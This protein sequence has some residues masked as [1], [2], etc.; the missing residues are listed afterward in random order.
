MAEDR[1]SAIITGAA[2]GIGLATAQKLAADGMNLCLVDQNAEVLEA[3]AQDLSN[4]GVEVIHRAADVTKK[5]DIEAFV[6]AALD[7]F[8]RVD[9]L[10][11]IAGGAGPRNLYQI[12]EF[13][14]DDWDLVITLNLRS[15]FLACRAVIPI[16]REQKYGRI[17]NMSSSVARGRTGPVGTAGG[18]L[19]YAAAKAGILGLTSQL[20]KD[21]GQF[22]I[23]VNAVMPWLT[24]SAQGTRIRQKFEALEPELR[25]QILSLSPLN[26]P[27][28]AGEVG[29]AIA[30]L[31]SEDASYVSG[32]GMPVD[33][34]YL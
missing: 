14:D 25:E 34:A 27:A 9:A 8:G 22:G 32:V 6:A 18:R 3:T 31:A 23:T 12:D 4:T 26:R 15:T 10:A 11:N 5:T 7:A 17:V 13:D 28:E 29:A 24:L 30:F 1:R 20:A 33:G 16:M 2:Q 19:A 21:V